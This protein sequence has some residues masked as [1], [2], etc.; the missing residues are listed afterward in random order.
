MA[1]LGRTGSGKTFAVTKLVEEMLDARAQVIV[2]DPVGVW[3]GLRL[4]ADG[5]SPGIPITIFGGLHGDVPLE[6]TG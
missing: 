6:S 5:K 1:F 2:L 4:L 3:W